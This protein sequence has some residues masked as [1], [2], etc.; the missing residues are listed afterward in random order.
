VSGSG[1]GGRIRIEYF[2]RPD[3]NHLY[4][5]AW[6][7]PRTEGPPHSVHGGAT[8]AVLDEAMGAVCWMNNHRV[9]GAR[10]TIN[11]AHMVPLGFDGRVEAWIDA[12]ERRKIT[13][14]GRL[15]DVEGKIYAES[16]GLFIELPP[17]KLAAMIR[18]D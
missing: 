8:A 12:V 17:E 13:T 6:F 2:R 4:A 5:L 11:Y 9:V 3:H 15:S 7:G 14:R 18:P 16:E 10:I 1:G